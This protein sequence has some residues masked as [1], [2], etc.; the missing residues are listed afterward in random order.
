[1]KNCDEIRY[2]DLMCH[3]LQA[4]LM[5]F[6]VIAQSSLNSIIQ[7]YNFYDIYCYTY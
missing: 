3:E 5:L 4:H 2:I 7:I 1:M 6:E